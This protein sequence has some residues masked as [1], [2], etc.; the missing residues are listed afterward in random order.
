MRSTFALLAVSIALSFC[1][2]CVCTTALGP[3]ACDEST[4]LDVVG[5]LQYSYT[6]LFL[7]LVDLDPALGVREVSFGITYDGAA[8]S[9]VD[10][11]TWYQCLDTAYSNAAP[12]PAWPAAGSWIRIVFDDCQGTT[13]N[14]LDPDGDGSV[15]LGGYSLWAVTDDVFSVVPASWSLIK[16]LYGRSSPAASGKREAPPRTNPARAPPRTGGLSGQHVR[17]VQL[18]VHGLPVADRAVDACGDGSRH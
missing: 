11:V 7:Q 6:H 2:P 16:Q 3:Y 15:V 17:V 4:P 18:E 8:D 13:P 12:D 14:P 10:D 5:D 9:G 1:L